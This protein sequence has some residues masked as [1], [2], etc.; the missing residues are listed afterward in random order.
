[1]N[2]NNRFD[3]N[4]EKLSKLRGLQKQKD[5][6]VMDVVATL[7]GCPGAEVA[8]KLHGHM[9]GVFKLKMKVKPHSKQQ[10]APTGTD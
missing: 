7:P 2:G 8:E 4:A 6:V 5:A 10:D 1:M 3:R 9:N